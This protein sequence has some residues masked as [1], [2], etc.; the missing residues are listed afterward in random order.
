MTAQENPKSKKPVPQVVELPLPCQ[1]GSNQFYGVH[2][3]TLPGKRKAS[4]MY[5]CIKCHE[6]RL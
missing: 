4:T 3:L 6:Y 2:S 5:E 1:C